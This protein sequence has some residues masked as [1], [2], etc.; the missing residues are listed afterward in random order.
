MFDVACKFL[1]LWWWCGNNRNDQSVINMATIT[2][3]DGYYHCEWLLI[4]RMA[5]GIADGYWYCGW[6]G[7]GIADGY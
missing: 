6:L 1:E 3:A 2:M 5:I 7:I 4:L